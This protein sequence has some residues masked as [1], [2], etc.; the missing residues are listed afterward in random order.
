MAED[1]APPLE[2][3][4]EPQPDPN[5]MMTYTDLENQIKATEEA[6]AGQG[7]PQVSDQ[8]VA[9]PSE[10]KSVD[11]FTDALQ[12]K[13]IKT[14][15]DLLKS[16]EEAHATITRLSQ[17]RAKMA[18][19]MDV[20]MQMQNQ[21][22][23]S[24]QAQPQVQ[25]QG[26]FNDELYKEIAPKVQAE[27]RMQAQAI[28]H[29]E[30]MRAKVESKVRE[31]PEEFQELNPIM[32]KLLEQYPQVS[33]LPNGFEMVYEKAREIRTQRVGK[34]LKNIFGPDVD[35]DKMREFFKSGG[36]Q[37]TQ[38][39]VQQEP[40]INQDVARAAYLPGSST[41]TSQHSQKPVDYDTQ[42][43]NLLQTGPQDRSFVDQVTDAWWNKNMSHPAAQTEAQLRNRR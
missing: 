39:P 15:E 20:L 17:E 33:A 26:D 3:T 35:M 5:R 32:L 13:G 25:G 9:P 23:Q 6:Q 11:P 28:L 41:S 34:L 4:Q 12:K 1:T 36:G 18:Q 19:D 14:P 40:A 37:S 22:V 31:N 30:R 27:A 42:M 2:T 38:P 43:R 24:Q 16:Y 29:E 10:D 7:Q 8:Q 21:F